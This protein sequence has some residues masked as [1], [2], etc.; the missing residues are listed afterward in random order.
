MSFAS[1]SGEKI[2]MNLN[3]PYSVSS[4][5]PFMALLCLLL[6]PFALDAKILQP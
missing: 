2:P 1:L 5:S 4:S 6:L 3:N